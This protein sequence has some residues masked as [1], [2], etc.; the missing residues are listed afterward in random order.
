MVAY[1]DDA[2]YCPHVCSGSKPRPALITCVAWVFQLLKQKKKKTEKKKR[3]KKTKK[4]K[5]QPHVDHMHAHELA[6]EDVTSDGSN[7]K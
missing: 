5:K 6:H 4:K 3:K 2:G 7:S 1:L